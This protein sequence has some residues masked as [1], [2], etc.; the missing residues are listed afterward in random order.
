MPERN[1][2]LRQERKRLSGI[3]KGDVCDVIFVDHDISEKSS[4]GIPDVV[5]AMEIAPPE[6][7]TVGYTKFIE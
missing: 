2:S 7:S 5:P 1:K 4:R 6:S 3:F